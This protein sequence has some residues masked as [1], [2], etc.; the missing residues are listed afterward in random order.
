VAVSFVFEVEGAAFSY[1]GE[2]ERALDGVSLRVPVGARLGL[3]G[4]NGA[5]KSTLLYHL[6]LLCEQPLQAGHITCRLPGLEEVQY[7]RISP[8]KR[9][10]LRCR[11]FGFALQK[12]YLM[13]QLTCV[14]NVAVPLLLQGRPEDEAVAAAGELLRQVGGEEL[15]AKRDRQRQKLSGGEEQMVAAARAIIHSPDVL[16]A[17]EPTNAMDEKNKGRFR[18]LLFGWHAKGGPAGPRT[19]LLVSHDAALVADA[20]ELIVFFRPDHK[21]RDGRAFTKAEVE[22]EAK[23]DGISCAE[24]IRRWIKH[25]C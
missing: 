2:D 7:D 18:D 16:F 20:A 15:E 25:E 21:L 5:G 13:P 22:E 3:V 6:G 8:E 10:R 4:P 24:R 12:A 9:A 17:D 23:A 11:H 1:E 14:E 19:L